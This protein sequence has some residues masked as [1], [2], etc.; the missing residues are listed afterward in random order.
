MIINSLV[1]TVKKLPHT[2]TEAAIRLNEFVGE[3]FSLAGS[4]LL[5]E[6]KHIVNYLRQFV[7]GIKQD[8]LKFYHVS[9]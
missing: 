7:D 6:V 9:N 5:D 2:L 3:V 8:I 1:S 4:T